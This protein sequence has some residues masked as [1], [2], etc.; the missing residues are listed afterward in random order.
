MEF[1]N[2]ER[3]LTELINFICIFGRLGQPKSMMRKK[4]DRL[5]EE[6]LKKRKK[7][8]PPPLP[9]DPSRWEGCKKC[10]MDM[11]TKQDL[12]YA[13]WQCFNSYEDW[14]RK[15]TAKR[16]SKRKKTETRWTKDTK[17]KCAGETGEQCYAR[18]LKWVGDFKNLEVD[19]PGFLDEFRKR[20]NEQAEQ[21]GYMR[22]DGVAGLQKTTEWEE[23]D[24]GVVEAVRFEVEGDEEWGG[25][26]EEV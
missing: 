9:L 10:I 4:M 21:L 1:L 20:V 26:I 3:S 12:S 8:D 13:L 7:D 24:D 15:M 11:L 23:F 6:H 19:E 5:Y 17:E 18:L 16:G 25:V 22:E 14:N 2:D